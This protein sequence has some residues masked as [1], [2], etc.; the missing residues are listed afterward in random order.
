[1]YYTHILRLIKVP[2]ITEI[3]LSLVGLGLEE[4]W[5]EFGEQN[6]LKF[7]SVD[8]KMY[9]CFWICELSD[10]LSTPTAWRTERSFLIVRPPDYDNLS[11]VF[12]SAQDHRRYA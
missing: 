12:F 10:T 8:R 7:A 2:E 1:L 5:N 11:N 3:N 9:G 6:R 4:K